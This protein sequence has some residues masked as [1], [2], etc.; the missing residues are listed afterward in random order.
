M[1]ILIVGTVLFLIEIK[2]Q[3]A[4]T[5][6]ALTQLKTAHKELQ[7]SRQKE[8]TLFEQKEK[9]FKMFIQASKEHEK[10]FNLMQDSE[11]THAYELMVNPIYFAS[12]KKN[13]KKSLN[14]LNS[15]KQR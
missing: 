9:T 13:L 11:L 5:E 6:G 15:S 14:I 7:D 2:K 1:L 3:Q 4:E 10:I 12:P 8:K